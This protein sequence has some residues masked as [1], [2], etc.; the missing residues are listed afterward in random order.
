[1]KTTSQS[2]ESELKSRPEQSSTDQTRRIDF[3]R[4]NKNRRLGTSAL[5]DML[6]WEARWLFKRAEVVGVWVWVTFPAKQP[7]GVTR[8]LSEF[9][10]HWNRTRQAWQHPSGQFRDKLS[11]DHPRDI[12]GSYFPAGTLST[13]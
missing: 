13:R 9:G 10:F 5:L 7:G 11:V 6:Y 4:R 3:K 2:N 12:Y 8:T 1:M